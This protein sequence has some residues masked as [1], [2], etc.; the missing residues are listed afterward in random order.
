MDLWVWLGEASD[1]FL[2]LYI[3]YDGHRDILSVSVNSSD[4]PLG[5]QPLL[6][7]LQTH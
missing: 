7:W 1:R 6:S 5:F 4:W 3:L 2:A